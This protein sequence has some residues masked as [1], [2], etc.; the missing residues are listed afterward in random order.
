MQN[1]KE[2]SERILRSISREKEQSYSKR[3]RVGEEEESS[4]MQN[5]VLKKRNR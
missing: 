4:D 5:A 2:T 3:S 1:H